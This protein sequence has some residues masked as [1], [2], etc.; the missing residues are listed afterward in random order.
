[1]NVITQV[2]CVCMCELSLI[3]YKT[4]F[5]SGNRRKKRS[6]SGTYTIIYNRFDYSI[7]ALNLTSF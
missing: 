3:F 1:M 5:L 2:I 7:N 4:N 6:N